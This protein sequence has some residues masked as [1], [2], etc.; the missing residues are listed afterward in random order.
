M[1]RT[2]RRSSL[3]GNW[4]NS[5]SRA[6]L[7]IFHRCVRR[8]APSR[9][10]VPVT[11]NRTPLLPRLNAKAQSLQLLVKPPK[12]TPIRALLQQHRT[13]SRHLSHFSP[14]HTP[15]TPLQQPQGKTL[16]RQVR[17]I[18]E[19][20]R[21]TIPPP[22]AAP[23]AR[24]CPPGC[25]IEDQR[26]PSPYLPTKQKG[27]GDRPSQPPMRKRP[28]FRRSVGDMRGGQATRRGPAVL[29]HAADRGDDA[30]R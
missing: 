28:S 15:G 19:V 8:W 11:G 17:S 29:L 20:A 12:Q 21:A 5:R 23:W 26:A 2:T 25:R 10:S 1:A 16:C 27:A 22:R 6:S 7:S 9:A 14:A 4:P 3:C 18:R 30:S 13:P 24:R